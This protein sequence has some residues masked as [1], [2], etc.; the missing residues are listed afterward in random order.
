MTPI[1]A[2]KQCHGATHP[3]CLEPVARLDVSLTDSLIKLFPQKFAAAE[4]EEPAAV[5]VRVAVAE[6]PAAEDHAIG[7]HVAQARTPSGS[8]GPTVRVQPRESG[9]SKEVC[10]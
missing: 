7:G 4:G 2:S 10:R 3:H 9:V 1:L 5:I 6:M 8:V